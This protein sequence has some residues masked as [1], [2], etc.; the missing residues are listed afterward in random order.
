MGFHHSPL[1]YLK[2][3]APQFVDVTNKPELAIEPEDN[4]LPITD[5]KDT[6]ARKGLERTAKR[7][8][9]RNNLCTSVQQTL[10]AG[11]TTPSSSRSP[12]PT[13][14]R[15]SMPT[16]SCCPKPAL[17][18]PPVLALS[19]SLIPASSRSPLPTL[20]SLPMPVLLSPSVP[21]LLCFLVPALL[22]RYVL[23]LAPTHLISSTLRIIKRP[24]SDEPLCRHLTSSS[25]V[26]SFCPFPI[27][28]PL[29]KTNNRKRPFDITFI[30]AHLLAENHAVEEVDLSFREY[31]CL[32]PIKLNCLW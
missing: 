12:L 3:V 7:K 9:R 14:F 24:L 16:L 2:D 11:S 25:P 30:N 21:A 26:E 1:S 28:G 6:K 8:V 17:S 20:L 18:H 15:P 4:N 29:P 13:L 22:S 32:I 31:G 10:A 5:S 19:S 23:G 27:L